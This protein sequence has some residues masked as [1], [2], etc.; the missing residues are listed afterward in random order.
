MLASGIVITIADF[1]RVDI[2]V[3]RIVTAEEFP[4]ARKP[5]EAEPG[6][7]VA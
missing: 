3:G 6:S 7:P 4:Q 5:S 2:R 1:Q